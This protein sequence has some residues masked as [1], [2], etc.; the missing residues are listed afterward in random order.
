MTREH[1]LALILGFAV[2]LVV[3]I[4][5]SDHFSTARRAVIGVEIAAGRP[6][7][8]SVIQDPLPGP[9]PLVGG[10]TLATTSINGTPLP[11][12]EPLADPELIGPAVAS[13]DGGEPEGAGPKVIVMDGRVD[14]LGRDQSEDVPEGFEAVGSSWRGWD[15]AVSTEI[16]PSPIQQGAAK[17]GESE[18]GQANI[19][20]GRLAQV[21]AVELPVGLPVS[22]GRLREHAVS[23]D[24]SMWAIAKRYYGD[25]AL[26]TKLAEYNQGR[27][28]KGGVLRAGVTLRVPP[29]DVLLGKAAL[30]PD[31]RVDRS[32]A[33]GD[34]PRVRESGD[35]KRPA[36]RPRGELA[37][38]AQAKPGANEAGAA[39]VYV[40]RRNDTL[41]DISRALL[42]TSKRYREIY[43][44]NRGVLPDPDNLVAG[45]S[46][47]IPSR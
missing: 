8:E 9:A 46:L 38:R 4:L 2:L 35:A 37:E 23:K 5:V 18:V 31:A 43:E 11:D 16:K 24:D 47:K 40:V 1:K 33:G 26:H 30:A 36:D 17:A 6:G 13:L 42:G 32:V 10:Q 22:T 14:S 45:V 3:G 39:R 29:R 15:A 41:G 25:G 28:S 44:L 27:L 19:D 20:K 34:G 21:G 12:P 7:V